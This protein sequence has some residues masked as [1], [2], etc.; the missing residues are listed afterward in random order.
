MEGCPAFQPV[1][2]VHRFPLLRLISCHC[3]ANPLFT[4][5]PDWVLSVEVPLPY[6]IFSVAICGW[7]RK[8]VIERAALLPSLVTILLAQMVG[9]RSWDWAPKSGRQARPKHQPPGRILPPLQQSPALFTFR[10]L[11]NCVH[12]LFILPKKP[13]LRAWGSCLIR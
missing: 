3:T 11:E 5:I 10:F 4:F 12:H 6:L 13:S 2:T 8:C 1:L 9:W 7:V